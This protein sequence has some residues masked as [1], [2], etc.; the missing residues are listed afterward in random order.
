MRLTICLLSN[1]APSLALGTRNE[2]M[3]SPHS[4]ADINVDVTHMQQ[5]HKYEGTEERLIYSARER[6]SGLEGEG[7][8]SQRMW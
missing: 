6:R 2:W 7:K 5:E 8:V 1:Q 4:Q 3:V